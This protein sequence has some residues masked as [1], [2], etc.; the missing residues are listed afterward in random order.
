MTVAAFVAPPFTQVI[1]G[2]Y[3]GPLTVRAGDSVQLLNARVVGPVIVEPGGKLTV[4]NSQVSRGIVAN[5]PGFLMICGSQIS[6]PSPGQALGVFD[7][8]VPVVIGD[9]STGCAGN[10][11]AGTVNLIGNVAL[12]FGSNIVSHTVTVNDGGPGI[13]VL[14]SNTIY[15]NLACSGNN[16]FESTR[17]QTRNTVSGTRSGQC[18]APF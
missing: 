6:G 15:G 16:P 4:I 12:T 3:L 1:T 14:K 9:A 8:D 2:D 5:S 7:S 10:R 11:F 13:T 18:V 17:P